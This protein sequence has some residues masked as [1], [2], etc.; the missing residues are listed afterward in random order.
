MNVSIDTLDIRKLDVPPM[1]PMVSAVQ[2]VVV[3]A[4][5][6]YIFMSCVQI[7]RMGTPRRTGTTGTTDGAGTKSTPLIDSSVII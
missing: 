4:M 1:P 6:M 7:W 5:V 2:A 3:A